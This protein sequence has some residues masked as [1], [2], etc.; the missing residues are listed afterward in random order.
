VPR[1]L[2][3]LHVC[4]FVLRNQLFIARNAEPHS[5]QHKA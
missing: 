3:G 5:E 4:G 2:S 1:T